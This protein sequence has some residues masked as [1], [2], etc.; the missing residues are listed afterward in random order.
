MYSPVAAG[1][2]VYSAGVSPLRYSE[3]TV[4]VNSMLGNIKCDIRSYDDCYTSHSR[5]DPEQ[6]VYL[7]DAQVSN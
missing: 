1:Y 3:I 2:Y 4:R 6:S 5:D 7:H